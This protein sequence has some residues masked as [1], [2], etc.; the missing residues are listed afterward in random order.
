MVSCCVYSILKSFLQHIHGKPPYMFDYWADPV[1]LKS[2]NK[3]EYTISKIFY[4][5]VPWVV[6]YVMK[7]KLD[8]H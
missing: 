2:S 5:I 3:F 1:I 6:Y 8:Y 4:D 7:S